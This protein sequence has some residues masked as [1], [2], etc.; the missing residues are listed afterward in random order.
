MN[1]KNHTILIGAGGV[2]SYLVPAWCKTFPHD[3][4]IIMDGDRLE[5]GNLDRQLFDSSAIGQYKATALAEKYGCK[6]INEY[7][8]HESLESN[9]LNPEDISCILCAVDNH[10]ARY[11]TI[12]FSH[13]YR[14]W[15]ISA[16]LGANE[17]YTSQAYIFN[18]TIQEMYIDNKPWPLFKYPEIATDKSH[19]PTNPSC[20]EQQESEPQLAGVNMITASL[21][22]QLAIRHTAR[23]TLGYSIFKDQDFGD[24]AYAPTEFQT[25]FGATQ[26]QQLIDHDKIKAPTINKEET[27]EDKLLLA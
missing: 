7:F 8:D 26:T 17:Y 9:D 22:M 11:E 27:R 25:T 23:C 13:D 16:I 20:V 15:D 18:P 1:N 12:K 14:S 24:L 21:M 3:N 2:S 6:A 10:V 19:D 4:L 5:K